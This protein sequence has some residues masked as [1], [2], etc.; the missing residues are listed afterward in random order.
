MLARRHWEVHCVVRENEYGG[1]AAPEA[2]TFVK[3]RDVG[4]DYVAG[5]LL[6]C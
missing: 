1:L 3:N 4:N 2:E 6:P 5:P